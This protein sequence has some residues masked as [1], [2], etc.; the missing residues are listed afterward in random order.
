LGKKFA[1]FDVSVWGILAALAFFLFLHM[2]KI[3]VKVRINTQMCSRMYLGCFKKNK[4]KTHIS[5]LIIFVP[6]HDGFHS[7]GAR[8]KGRNQ[9]NQFLLM[10]IGAAQ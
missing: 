8:G 1:K 3:N 5:D 6:Q 2:V 10:Y 4:T 7:P 9:K